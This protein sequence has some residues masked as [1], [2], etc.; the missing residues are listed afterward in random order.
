MTES[1][2]MHLN[3]PWFELVRDKKKLYEGRRRTPKT[4]QLKTG[5][6]ISIKHYTK[7]DIEEPYKVSI[8]DILHFQTF[9]DALKH[10][11]LHDVLPIDDISVE[12]GVEIYQRY[13]S[14][15]TQKSDGVI[16]LKIKRCD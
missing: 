7:P 15:Q 5:D 6:I 8:E 4:S 10:L 13:V 3:S 2:V 16:M 12:K 9:E 11:P 14:L 1:N